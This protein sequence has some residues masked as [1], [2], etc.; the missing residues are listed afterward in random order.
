M[1]DW[2]APREATAKEVMQRFEKESSV[3]PGLQVYTFSPPIWLRNAT[4]LPFQMVL[5]DT[6]GFVSKIFTST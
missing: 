1:K 3:L 4:G 2:D 6:N 5:E